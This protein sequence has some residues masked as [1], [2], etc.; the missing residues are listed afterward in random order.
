MDLLQGEK[1]DCKSFFRKLSETLEKY[2]DL[3]KKAGG[4]KNLDHNIARID[5]KWRDETDRTAN[6]NENIKL[7][8]SKGKFEME[9]VKNKCLT[10]AVVKEENITFEHT[11]VDD[12]N[13]RASLLVNKS[14]DSKDSMTEILI[15]ID[16]VDLLKRIEK[17]VEALHKSGHL[18]FRAFQDIFHPNAKDLDLKLSNLIKQQ[19]KWLDDLG[20]AR[21][22]NYHMN[23]LQGQNLWLFSDFLLNQ[24]SL[25]CNKFKSL[26][27]YIQLGLSDVVLSIS[28]KE[29]QMYLPFSLDKASNFLSNM[30]VRCQK[31][32]N[33]IKQK[34]DSLGVFTLFEEEGKML[35]LLM[36]LFRRFTQIP[37]AERILFATKS[38]SLEQIDIFLNRC[39][40]APESH[41]GGIYAILNCQQMSL[42]KQQYLAR[43]IGGKKSKSNS[44]FLHTSSKQD[45]L[46]STFKSV[47]T[48]EEI[49]KGIDEK[50]LFSNLS[51]KLCFVSSTISGM[52]K[53]YYIEKRATLL[54]SLSISGSVDIIKLLSS[55]CDETTKTLHIQVCEHTNFSVSQLLFQISVLRLVQSG[56]SFQ[57]IPPNIKQVYVEIANSLKD[58]IKENLTFRRYFEQ[59][60]LDWRKAFAE[61]ELSQKLTSDE[62]IVCNYLQ[63]ADQ[64][65]ISS[66]ILHWTNNVDELNALNCYPNPANITLMKSI[67]PQQC[68]QI[69]EKHFCAVKLSNKEDLS[70]S[71]IK[72]FLKT[73]SN[74]LRSFSCADMLNP[75]S[76]YA[77]T[78]PSK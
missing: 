9:L 65:Q 60:E 32:A 31:V 4:L 8:V 19:N 64:N 20:Y 16:C 77:G 6:T 47:L 41:Q 36:S 17:K 7:I 26:L 40:E 2:Q 24:K 25:D 18:D 27:E 66:T 74:Q 59:V 46:L 14:K 10:K 12:F 1:Q 48:V 50:S 62:Q 63:T 29:K 33:P 42:S 44:L 28:T 57:C 30:L 70:L 43:Q 68:K 53:T 34:Q 52:G 37:S 61:L 39:F 5:R 58:H 22:Q 78:I 38:T 76:L 72:A 3:E 15:F 45:Y 67:P 54:K 56:S 23:F 51:V 21:K 69:L 75:Y 11:K 35:E 71:L 73:F 13:A 55:V 49:K